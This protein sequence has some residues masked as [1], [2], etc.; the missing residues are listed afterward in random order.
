MILLAGAAAPGAGSILPGGGASA[1]QRQV[2]RTPGRSPCSRQAAV[3]AQALFEGL[4]RSRSRFALLAA[5]SASPG[6]AVA[7]GSFAWP[8][9]GVST[10]CRLAN[11]RGRPLGAHGIFPEH[12]DFEIQQSQPLSAERT[13]G[14]MHSQ[15]FRRL[16][17]RRNRQ[18][19]SFLGT[20]QTRRHGSC[21]RRI[22]RRRSG[23]A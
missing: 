13:A 17:S 14:K 23:R 4:I 2:L 10:L 1:T 12:C 7:S 5:N 9:C 18:Q 19:L 15:L 20:C 3:S 16:F 8:F 22:R 11:S 21:P 6:P